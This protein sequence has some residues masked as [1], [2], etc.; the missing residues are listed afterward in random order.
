MS[1]REVVVLSAVRTPVGEFGGTLK[2]FEPGELGAVVVKE[3]IKRAG[4]DPHRI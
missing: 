2:D 4:T 1:N 3:A